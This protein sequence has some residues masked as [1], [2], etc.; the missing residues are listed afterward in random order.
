MASRVVVRRQRKDVIERLKRLRDS[1]LT[2]GVHSSA[3][4][5]DGTSMALIAAVHEFG[6]PSVGVPERAPIRKAIA[7]NLPAYRTWM[8]RIASAYVRR[9]VPVPAG[10]NRLGLKIVSDIRGVI[11]DGLSP[12]LAESTKEKR[13]AKLAGNGGRARNSVFTD[14]DSWTPLIDTGRLLNSYGHEVETKARS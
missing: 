9:G 1:R 6:A 13:R 4:S 5:S 12:G 3:G 7:A 8:K 11:H 14:T 2:V 10:L